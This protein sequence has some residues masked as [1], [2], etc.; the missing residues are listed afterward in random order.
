MI[1]G[2]TCAGA[3]LPNYEPSA[4]ILNLGMLFASMGMN[5]E[6]LR[7]FYFLHHDR[8]LLTDAVMPGLGF[9][10]CRGLWSSLSA[11]AK[12][13]GGCFLVGLA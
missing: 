13:T 12:I 7:Q 4:A 1:I 11:P 6:A 10:L 8:E 9:L 5:L 2:V 3:L